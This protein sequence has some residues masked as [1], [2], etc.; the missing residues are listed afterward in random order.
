MRKKRAMGGKSTIDKGAMG[1]DTNTE[2]SATITTTGDSKGLAR[3]NEGMAPAIREK[4][5]AVPTDKPHSSADCYL[6]PIYCCF[7]FGSC[8]LPFPRNKKVLFDSFDSSTLTAV[9]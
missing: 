4:K 6:L 2:L 1:E 7:Y 8:L 9:C 5:P 3:N